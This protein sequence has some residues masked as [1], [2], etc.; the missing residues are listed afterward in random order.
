MQWE[1][2]TLEWVTEEGM[3]PPAT[4]TTHVQAL[5][6]LIMA[7]QNCASQHTS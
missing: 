6:M 3:S 5:S 1:A 2:N 7:S 4:V